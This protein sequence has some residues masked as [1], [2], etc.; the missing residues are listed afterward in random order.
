MDQSSLELVE[1]RLGIGSVGRNFDFACLHPAPNPIDDPPAI[2][3]LPVTG[4]ALHLVHS[5][6]ASAVT[7][8][9]STV[10]LTDEIAGQE[11]PILVLE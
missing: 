3:H 1:P 8:S 7:L 5:S 4:C 9:M 6:T 2:G 11:H 10:V